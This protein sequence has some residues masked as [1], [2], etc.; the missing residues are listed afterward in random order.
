MRLP[1]P[2]L[3][4]SKRS[5]PRHGRLVSVGFAAI[6]L[7]VGLAGC[8]DAPQDQSPKGSS[9]AALDA[10]SEVV[11]RVN[12][13]PIYRIDVLAHAAEKRWIKPN[14][15]LDTDSQLFAQ[16]VEELIARKLYAEEAV[17][18]KLDQDEDVQRRLARARE[19]VL[20]QALEA[21]LAAESLSSE[22]VEREYRNIVANSPRGMKV[23]AW[24]IL[25]DT[26]EEAE[27]ARRQIDRG[28]DF[29]KVAAQRSEEPGNRAEG[30]YMSEFAPEDLVDGLRQAAETA[31]VGQV[32]GPIQ[33]SKGF[34]LLKVESRRTADPAT[35]E[36]MR[37]NIQLWLIREAR[38]RL[39]DRLLADARIE[40]LRE[41]AG[42]ELPDGG[43]GTQEPAA[44]PPLAAPAPNQTPL[45]PGAIAGSA[46]ADLARPATPPPAAP[47]KAA[48]PKTVATPAAPRPAE[49]RAP[50]AAPTPTEARKAP[51]P[52]TTPPPAQRS[53]PAIPPAPQTPPQ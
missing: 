2:S 52:I 16:A 1:R 5:A 8:G 26:R 38:L 33:T 39:L 18:Q 6:L 29:I 11:A 44:A 53:P 31:P 22:A 3:S 43:L 40:R 51:T 10:N 14:E 28:E 36:Q 27:S 41:D 46:G 50:A 37:P 7:A 17:T 42:V 21:K 15:D 23:R 9:T 45:G 25:T 34:Y 13:S 24:T 49:A 32:V 4:P 47:P 12:G 20:S 19:I 48:P 30:G 35:L